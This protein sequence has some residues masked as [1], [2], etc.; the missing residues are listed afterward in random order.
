MPCSFVLPRAVW[1]LSSR[2]LPHSL[3][4]STAVFK[5]S[6]YSAALILCPQ[7]RAVEQRFGTKRGKNCKWGRGTKVN[8]I[9]ITRRC[10]LEEASEVWRG[11][12]RS[13]LKASIILAIFANA[14]V[15]K[16]GTQVLTFLCDFNRRISNREMSLNWS[17][18]NYF[19]WNISN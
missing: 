11:A 6:H 12:L 17:Y 1:E 8:S 10:C 19:L 3:V 2:N 9:R 16:G 5:H 7:S 13:F 14:T 18:L 4:L 15:L